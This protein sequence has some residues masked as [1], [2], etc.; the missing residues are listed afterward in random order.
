MIQHRRSLQL[1]AE[2]LLEDR[3]EMT[4]A[5]KEEIAAGKAD[6]VASKVRIRPP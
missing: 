1:A 2:N 3:L 5:F 4:D 6:I